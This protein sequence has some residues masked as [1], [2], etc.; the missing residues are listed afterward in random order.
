MG[1]SPG[2]AW[3]SP[4]AMHIPGEATQVRILSATPPL[5][6]R[7]STNNWWKRSTDD[8]EWRWGSS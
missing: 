7:A 3:V 4:T 6:P 2:K 1:T 8:G 5:S